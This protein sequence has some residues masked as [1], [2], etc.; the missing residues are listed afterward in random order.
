MRSS[1]SNRFVLKKFCLSI[2]FLSVFFGGG[3]FFGTTLLNFPKPIH[4]SPSPIV[5][6]RFVAVILEKEGK[7]SPEKALFSALSQNYEPFRVVYIDDG[8]KS[9]H[10]SQIRDLVY[11]L[12]KPEK[13]QFI[14]NQEPLGEFQNLVQVANECQKNEILILIDE[15]AILSH[16][17]VF[18]TLNRYYANPSLRIANG[19]SLN[20]NTFTP[21]L[22]PLRTFYASMLKNIA[23]SFAIDPEDL[24]YIEALQEL[25]KEHFLSLEE[26]LSLV[27]EKE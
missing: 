6:Q 1:Q 7:I 26:I 15:T 9:N 8:V 24:S 18:Q 22:P 4:P 17:W 21:T 19:K 12:G 25:G 23:E 10:F 3:F 14:Q 13:V 20:S 27:E 2:F 16:E 11:R 5:N